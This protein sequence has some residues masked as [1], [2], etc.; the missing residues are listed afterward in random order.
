MAQDDLIPFSE[1][2]EQEAKELGRIGGIK[3]GETR[4]A[5]R[6]AREVA[7]NLLNLDAPFSKAA[8]KELA[9]KWGVPE[10]EIDVMFVSLTSIA[11]K[12]MKGDMKA[13]EVI[14]DTAGEKP[15][16]KIDMSHAFAGDFEIVLGI[17]D[18]D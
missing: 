6:L 2:S 14:R 8:R 18:E 17:E 12:A 3:S 5:K 10:G 16:D 15:T 9:D 4:R 13:F 7:A 11:T 1:R